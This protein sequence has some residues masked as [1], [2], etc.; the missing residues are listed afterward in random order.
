MLNTIAQSSA[1]ITAWKGVNGISLG[2]DVVQQEAGWITGSGDDT[3]NG[4]DGIDTIVYSGPRSDYRIL[5]TA[6]G[7]V[8]VLDRANGDVDVIRQIEK[9]AFGADVI[10]L[11]FTQIS[12]SSLG[13]VGQYYHALLGRTGDLGGLNFWAATK[14]SPLALANAFMEASEYRSGAGALD[15]HAFVRFVEENVLSHAPDPASIEQWS[16]YLANHSR[17]EMVVALLAT[18]DALAAQYAGQGLWLL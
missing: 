8:T 12:A 2:G 14:L 4:G 1:H 16:G 6:Q 15:D 10:D 13:Q 3:L 9:G 18:P 17:A 5:L 7:E 11:N